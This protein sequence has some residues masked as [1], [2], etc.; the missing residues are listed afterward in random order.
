MEQRSMHPTEEH[1][2]IRQLVPE[3][4]ERK[5]TVFVFTSDLDFGFSLSTL[6]QDR[7]RVVTA[8]DPEMIETF[9]DHYKAELF[10]VDSLPSEEMI[11]HLQRLK[12]QQ[13]NVPVI[14]LYMFHPRED[15]HDLDIR[16]LVD[17]VI[18]KPLDLCDLRGKVEELLRDR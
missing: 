16:K 8:T 6:F 4:G 15:E 3:P 7:Y 12:A 14:V 10:I 1:Q 2:R 11:H 17:Y 13:A 9:L 18:Y 5:K